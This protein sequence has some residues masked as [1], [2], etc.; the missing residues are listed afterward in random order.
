MAERYSFPLLKLNEIRETFA[1]LGIVINEDDLATPAGWKVKQIYE[2]LNEL[3]LHQKREDLR[4][5][6]AFNQLDV[7]LEY[8]ELH[9]ESVQ[10]IAFMKAW[11]VT[12][13]AVY[14]AQP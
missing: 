4:E 9:E 13:S 5:Q 6:P 11:Y 3:L 14:F 8:P 1:E 2:K 7:Q 12:R 10:M